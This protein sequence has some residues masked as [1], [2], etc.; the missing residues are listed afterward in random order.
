MRVPT[1]RSCTVRRLHEQRRL[2]PAPR[3]LIA[4]LLFAS[5]CGGRTAHDPVWETGGSTGVEDGAPSSGLETSSGAAAGAG[6]AAG[7]GTGG[8]AGKAGLAGASGNTD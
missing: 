7:S 1:R 3:L 6:L 4:S 2:L 8:N 5:G